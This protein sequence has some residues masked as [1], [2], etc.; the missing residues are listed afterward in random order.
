MVKQLTLNKGH[1]L[2]QELLSAELQLSTVSTGQLST[3]KESCKHLS[4][5]RVIAYVCE[6]VKHHVQ[7]RYPDAYIKPL[8]ED[9]FNTG[10]IKLTPMVNQGCFFNETKGLN[11]TQTYHYALQQDYYDISRSSHSPASLASLA[12]EYL[13]TTS[14]I[15][16]SRLAPEHLQTTSSITNRTLEL[17]E[18]ELVSHSHFPAL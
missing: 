16:N 18:D 14:S 12:P 17:V 3:A 2:L 8:K 9:R 7:E 13:Q 1:S 5:T 11:Y 10:F 6:L 4:I 15:T